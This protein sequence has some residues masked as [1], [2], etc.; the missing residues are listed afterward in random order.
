MTGPSAA[1]RETAAILDDL[2]AAGVVVRSLAAMTSSGERYRAALPVL[3]DWLRRA[4]SPAV[5]RSVAGALGKRWARPTVNQALLDAFRVEQD[6]DVRF[7]LGGAVERTWDDRWFD[8]VVALV[9][10]PS[11]GPSRGR[12]VA[13]LGRSRRPEAVAVLLGLVDDSDVRGEAI[14]ALA[15]LRTP[16]AV[17]ALLGALEHGPAWA[18]RPARRAL[19][20]LDALPPAAPKAPPKRVRPPVDHDWY[21]STEWNAAIAEAFEARLARSR[22]SRGEYLR[23]QGGTLAVQAAADEATRRAGR[24]LLRRYLAERDRIGASATVVN[25][26]HEELGNSYVVSGRLDDAVDEY[27][28]ALRGIA[29]CGSSSFTSGGTELLLAEVLLGKGDAASLAEADALLV[30][31]EPEILRTAFFRNRVVRW[32][33]ALARVAH[34]RGRPE[35]AAEHARS[36]LAIL[37]VEGSLF[38]RHPGVGVPQDDP[39]LVRELRALADGPPPAR[40]VRRRRWSFFRR[41]RP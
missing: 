33:T 34:R 16:A 32:L 27:R 29:A 25:G 40:P 41:S 3:L 9:H 26:I 20:H 23:I 19:E 10:D 13:A 8:D 14:T 24:S 39:A 18:R 15:R 31:V 6:A 36:A 30:A 35:D 11:Y 1:E 2:R 28:T 7:A 22:S 37:A 12:A 21:R 5:R 4:D 38:P 17:P